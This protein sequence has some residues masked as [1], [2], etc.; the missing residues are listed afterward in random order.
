MVRESER[1][2]R[3]HMVQLEHCRTQKGTCVRNKIPSETHTQ[4]HTYRHTQKLIDTHR[5]T[6]TQDT[7]THTQTCT[8]THRERKRDTQ[9]LIDTHKHTQR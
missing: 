5:H 8:D 7:H 9:I 4:T 3:R 1:W 2:V 6:D